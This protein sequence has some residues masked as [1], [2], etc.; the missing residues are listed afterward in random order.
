MDIANEPTG[1]VLFAFPAVFPFKQKITPIDF[2]DWRF[3]FSDK[4]I[5]RLGVIA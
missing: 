3:G 4:T 1:L 5:S 2:F